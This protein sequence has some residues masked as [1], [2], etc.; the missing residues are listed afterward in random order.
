M[1]RFNVWGTNTATGVH[2]QAAVPKV[3]SELKV[4]GDVSVRLIV[5]LGAQSQQLQMLPMSNTDVRPGAIETQQMRVIA[6]PGVS[7]CLLLIYHPTRN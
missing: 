6:P 4:N 3:C 7:P 5:F 2:F 1:A